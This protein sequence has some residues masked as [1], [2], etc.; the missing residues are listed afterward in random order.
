MVAF[1]GDSQ[2]YTDAEDANHQAVVNYI[3]DTS[4]SSIFHAGDLLEDATEDSLNRFKNVTST[5]CST[6]GFY[7]AQGNNER[8]S[9]TY[10]DNFVFPGNEHWHSV[11]VGNLHMVVLDN[12][13]SSVTAG[14]AQYNWLA[15]DLQS[16]ASQSRATGV[17]FHYPVYGSD[18]G[19][20]GM[21]G[22]MVPLFRDYGVDFV[23]SGHEHAYQ[24]AVADGPVRPNNPSSANC[25]WLFGRH[26]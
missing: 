7:A 14:S 25:K 18:R 24:K 1:Y 6:R 12:Y 9:A 4:A 19:Y 13:A 10:F 26:G 3:L 5:L 8:N 16:D 15:S 2:S 22:S 17:I 20:K 21:T 11:N 23:V